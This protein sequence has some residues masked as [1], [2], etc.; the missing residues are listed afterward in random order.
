V[1]GSDLS[2]LALLRHQDDG[3]L[4]ITI[5]PL[6]ADGSAGTPSYRRR[7]SPRETEEIRLYLLG[8][9]DRLESSG[10]RGGIHVRVLGG[11]GNDRF[12]DAKSGGADLQDA[13]GE[14]VFLRGPGTDVSKK[15]WQN[16][17]PE[18]DRP[19]LEPRNY[20]HWTVPTILA[21]WEPT[22]EFMLGGGFART[23]WGFRKYPWANT[24]A[25]TVLYSTGYQNVRAT[26][27]GQWRLND[28]SVLGSVD[29]KGSGAENLNYFGFGN[30]TPRIDEKTLYKSEVNVYSVFPAL[31]YQ[32]SSSFE[33]HA[34]PEAKLVQTKGGD[35][36]VEMEQPYGVGKF[37][38][39]GLRA[40]LEY[41]SRGRAL[42]LTAQR[43]MA[44]PD[45]TA[46]L[47]P[48]PVSGVRIVAEGFF[49]PKA[50]DVQENFGGV[51]GSVAGYL[52]NQRLAL[53]TRIGGRAM[54][55]AYPWFESASIGGSSNVRG[56]D[57]GRF[58]GDSSLYGNAELRFWLGQR[59]GGVL[60]VRFGATTFVN[61]GRVWYED[62]SSKKWHTAWG[63]GLVA[64]LIGTPMALQGSIASGTEGIHFYVGGGFSF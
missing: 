4:E 24:Q 56:Y 63:G 11:P 7:F 17:A 1:R 38:E 29:M 64:Q 37:G 36:L 10:P 13:E 53:A 58:R 8:G 31:R 40:G 26:Y 45:A 15:A 3:S 34:G 33:L 5:A 42:G 18:A 16:P 44:A 14:N 12:D 52:G 43:G 60:P 22:Q 47:A 35:S 32:P 25:L 20:G 39:A 49:A 62:E 61:S 46:A 2:E 51:E 6:S 23:A 54:W 30:E 21:Y 28:S 9:N 50:W 59:K 19:W 27:A 48:A 55:G 57:S 41:D